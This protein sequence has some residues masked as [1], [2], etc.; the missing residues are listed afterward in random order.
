[1]DENSKYTDE[2]DQKNKEYII[3][4][5]AISETLNNNVENLGC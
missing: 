2:F 4:I 3:A 1:M 5:K